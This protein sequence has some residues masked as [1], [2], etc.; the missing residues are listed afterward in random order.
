MPAAD[1]S[2]RACLSARYGAETK[3]DAC[4]AY[5]ADAPFYAAR[6]LFSSAAGNGAAACPTFFRFSH[7]STCKSRFNMLQSA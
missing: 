6:P 5:R 7:H 4:S 3:I 1:V 2:M